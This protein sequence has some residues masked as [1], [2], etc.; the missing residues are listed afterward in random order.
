MSK[1]K[2]NFDLIPKAFQVALIGNPNCG[3]TTI[4]NNL[5]GTRQ[6]VGNWPGVT[7]EKK[8]GHYHYNKQDIVITDLPG[9][10]SISPAPQNNSIDQEIANNFIKNN[11]TDLYINILDASNLKR[12][13][14][15][16]LQ[17]RELGLPC[18]VILN[19]TDKS[20]FAKLNLDKDLLSKKLSELLGCPVIT[21]SGTKDIKNN[22]VN[23]KAHIA[24]TLNKQPNTTQP[25]IFNQH[26]FAELSNIIADLSKL[27]TAKNSFNNYGLAL[28][29]I[30]SEITPQ[31]AVYPQIKS[32]YPQI[33]AAKQA[34]TD[35]YQDDP[36]IIIA[37]LRYKIINQIYS[38][39]ID[40]QQ[41]QSNTQTSTTS[42]S[43]KIDN[44]VLNK[45]LGIPIFFLLLYIVFELAI[46]LGE[47]LK[48][49]FEIPSS[50]IVNYLSLF[51]S[52]TLS[53]P[54]NIAVN[55]NYGLSTGLATVMGFIPQIAIIFILL[56]CLEDSGYMARAAFV[57]DRLMLAVGLPGKSFLPLIISFGCNVPAIMSTRTLH[58]HQ[59]RILTCLMSPFMS[60]SAR[61]AIFIVF[62]SAF[63]PTRAALMV[64]ILYL[65]GIVIALITGLVL[66]K[67]I[68]LN[69]KTPFILELPS[70]NLPNAK[71]IL[72]TSWQ[73]IYGFITRAGKL[74]IPI[75]IV[76][77]FVN[78]IAHV[79]D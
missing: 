60:C 45:Y 6:K 41:K 2:S 20:Q 36:D 33:L 67:T 72:I 7:V 68:L 71:T 3:K 77:Q 29:Y 22:I 1:S 26:D 74:I 28:G 11:N 51:L 61:L 66:K 31:S 21:A 58:N 8:T 62:A 75:C 76:L 64:F 44:I 49:L 78:N 14:Y 59:D 46:S 27:L 52:N 10:Y 5:T 18:L 79:Q 53:L 47:E 35:H 57:M 4:F 39:C 24:Q 19:M 37:D 73:H 38:A 25:L 34:V 69:N 54:D 16:T 55:L 30:E 9:L 15:L 13:L 48:P 65:T 50:Y 40:Q 43:N 63:F 23:I 42:V 70:Y 17:L 32:I 56:T 12:N